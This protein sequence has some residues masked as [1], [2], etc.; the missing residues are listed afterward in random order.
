MSEAIR[1][2]PGRPVGATVRAIARQAD[3]DPVLVH[4]YF[5]SKGQVLVAAM[6]LPFERYSSNGE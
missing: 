6:E 3:V 5:G 4:R 2:G 1:R